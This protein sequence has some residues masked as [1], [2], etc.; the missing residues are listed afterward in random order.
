EP[1]GFERAMHFVEEK[2]IFLTGRDGLYPKL[3]SLTT[4]S[5]FAYGAGY[6]DSDSF[7]E[8]AIVDV[9][10]ATSTRLYWAAEARLTF[11]KLARNRLQLETWAAHRDYPEEDFFGLGP[12][13]RREDQT[14]YAIRSDILGAR[15]T[16]RLAPIVSAGGG[17]EWLNPRLGE[18]QDERVPSIDEI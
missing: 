5:G 3:G 6:R 8:N 18:G 13:S 17:M 7:N 12:D 1:G 11:P 16:V 14:S 15:A 10:A 2:G 9:W 4:G